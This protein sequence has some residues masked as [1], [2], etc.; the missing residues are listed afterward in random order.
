MKINNPIITSEMKI[1]MRSWRTPI[2]LI[3]YIG[4]L[5][6]FLLLFAGISVS[7]INSYSYSSDYSEVGVTI[8]Y[9]L[10][11]VQFFII[12]LVAPS[13]TSGAISSEREKQTLDLLLCTQMSPFKIIV[14][15]LVSSILWILVMAVSTIPLYSIA[16][17]FGGVNPIAVISVIAFYMVTAIAAGS[18][19]I[20]YSTVF[21]KTVTSSIMSYL[22][23]FIIFV[24]TLSVGYIEVYIFD[25]IRYNGNPHMPIAFYFNP[26]M[27]FLA[28]ASLTLSGSSNSIFSSISS[29]FSTEIYLLVGLD[30]VFLI[31]LTLL[32]LYI[33]IRR[34]DP[35]KGKKRYK[36]S[37][38]V[39]DGV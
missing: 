24:L 19:G 18:I 26:F 36:E 1:R 7:T 33:S 20:F 16:F 2:G 31:L 9:T 29:S 17:L 37:G 14:G 28:L 8:F 32:L 6:I 22:T 27:A 3:V 5:V 21:K 15:K 25:V 10:S 11:I 23:I 13:S 34:I 38:R 30:I 39:K 4:L 35:I 12:V